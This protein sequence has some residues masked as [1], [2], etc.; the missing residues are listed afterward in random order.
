M[1]KK[2][3]F[4]DRDGTLIVDKHYLSDPKDI[5]YFGDTFSALKELQKRGYELFIVTNQSGIGRGY[6][7]LEQMHQV[8]AQMLKDFKN[9]DITI[10]D[11]AFCPH[12]PKDQCDCRKP[13]PKMLLKLCQEHEVDPKKSFMVG[14]KEIDQECGEN[15]GMTGLLVGQDTSLTDL[16]EIIV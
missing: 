7:T 2:A 1:E 15:A 5:V 4:F 3:V 11:I 14:D 6:F 10:S 9:H 16:L 13:H 12:A 8:H